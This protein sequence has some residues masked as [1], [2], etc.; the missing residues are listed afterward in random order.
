M[1]II[2]KTVFG[3]L[4]ILMPIAGNAQV[5][6][7]KPSFERPLSSQIDSTFKDRPNF[8]IDGFLYLDMIVLAAT[9]TLGII[10]V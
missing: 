10:K 1:N 5:N 6:L 4:I 7:G 2:L 8:D 3:V 9:P